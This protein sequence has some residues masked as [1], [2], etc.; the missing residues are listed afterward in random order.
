VAKLSA[1]GAA[2]ADMT[3]GAALRDIA[4][5]QGHFASIIEL[6]KR[7]GTSERLATNPWVLYGYDATAPKDTSLPLGRY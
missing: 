7:W 3:T 2:A 4:V 1:T 6:G 5:R